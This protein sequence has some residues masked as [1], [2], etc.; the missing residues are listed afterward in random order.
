VFICRRGYNSGTQISAEMFL[1]DANCAPGT[2]KVKDYTLA[3]CAT[4]TSF[5]ATMAKNDGC[6]WVQAQSVAK[7]T[8]F[9]SGTGDL[10]D[11]LVG[12]DAAGHFAIGYASIDNLSAADQ[13]TA[14]RQDFRYIKVD[15][16]VPSIENAAAG[17]YTFVSQSFW[18]A[19]PATVGW[20]AINASGQGAADLLAV[21]TNK[22]TGTAANN[23]IGT[24]GSVAGVNAASKMAAQGF[25]G[26][27]LVIPGNNGA[28]PPVGSTTLTGFANSPVS[29][30]TKL[31]N[32]GTDTNNCARPMSSQS[33]SET[34]AGW[35]VYA[36]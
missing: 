31:G 14:K 27:V 2:Y 36:Q 11:C 18:Y 33:A 20:A 19:P 16:I 7:A 35:P 25:D 29:T 3:S 4:T 15:G 10:L 30:I 21:I 1:T 32:N 24:I 13:G 17:K 8:F 26:G 6:G 12:H 23:G 28:V 34:T 5:T 22:A 9:A